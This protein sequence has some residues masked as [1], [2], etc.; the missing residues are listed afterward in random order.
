MQEIQTRFGKP[1]AVATSCLENAEISTV[2]KWIRFKQQIAKAVISCVLL[3]L[4]LWGGFLLK[5]YLELQSE[6]KDGY[7]TQTIGIISKETDAPDSASNS[8]P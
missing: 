4:L 2:L 8:E 6:M 1:E 7:Q 3:A 5:V